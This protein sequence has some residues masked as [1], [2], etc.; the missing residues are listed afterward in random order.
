MLRPARWLGRLTSPR[1]P[2]RT[3]RPA[4]LRQSLPRP[5]SPPARVCYHYS[6]QPPISEAGFSPAR[7]SK[8]EGCTRRKRRERSGGLELRFLLCLLCVLGLAARTAWIS[9][10]VL[11]IFR[12]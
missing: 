12:G 9:F 2:F 5:E 3:D 8:N 10:R 1:L 6:A 7:V 11:R 4:R